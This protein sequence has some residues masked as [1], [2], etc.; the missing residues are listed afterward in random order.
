M[1]F[2]TIR[3]V[4]QDFAHLR[5]CGFRIFDLCQRVEGITEF[6]TEL[7]TLCLLRLLDKGHEG[8]LRVDRWFLIVLPS[9]PQTGGL[10]LL[11]GVKET[12]FLVATVGDV[13]DEA[14]LPCEE[15][16]F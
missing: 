15:R 12:W 16:D 11:R 9:C 14:F 1:E 3:R 10:D 2:P 6:K 4:E 7:G 13:L 5:V 8:Q